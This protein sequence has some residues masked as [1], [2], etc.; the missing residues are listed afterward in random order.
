M[1][2]AEPQTIGNAMPQDMAS[3]SGSFY[4]LGHRVIAFPD[5]ASV[6]K[7]RENLLTGGCD[8]PDMQHCGAKLAV[9]LLRNIWKTWACRQASAAP[10]RCCAIG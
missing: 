4:A 7:V 3:E 10:T 2:I 8:G 6:R 9:R 5:A 1:A